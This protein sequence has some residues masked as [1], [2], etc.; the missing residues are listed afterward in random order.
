VEWV[1]EDPSHR[2]YEIR[3][4]TAA[5]RPPLRPRAYTPLI[6]VGDLL[7]Y[8]SGRAMPVTLFSSAHLVD[9]TGDGKA[10]LVG[11]WNYAYRPGWPWSGIICYPRVGAADRFEF[12]GLTRVRYVD[13]AGSKA[14]NHFSHIYMAAAFADF[15]GDGRTDVVY[16]RSGVKRA[17]FYLNTGHRDAAGMPV[18]APSGSVAAPTWQPCHALDLNG[19]GAI[20]LVLGSSY[21]RNRNPNGWPFEPAKAVAL[22]AGR[23]PA[24]FDVDA[25][26]QLDAVCLRG[27]KA[28]HPHGYRVAWRKGLGGDPPRFGP[29]RLLEGIDSEMCSLVEAVDDGSRRGLLVQHNV[30]QEVA[31]YEHVGIE[32][33]KPSFKLLGRAE[34]K[35]AVLSMSDQAWPCV[36]DWDSDGEWD[37]LVGGG[38]GWPRI[39]INTGTNGRPA[40]AEAKLIYADGKPDLLTCVEWSVYP[41]F[42][43]VAI[44]M[45]ALPTCQLGKVSRR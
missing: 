35:T 44:E 17:D 12:G 22:D 14:Y 41:F 2:V 20:D 13:E 25:D 42:S 1:I 36:C 39:A 26:G 6:G 15:N 33:D 4:A 21:I 27:G 37:L 40:F 30:Y 9:L 23:R 29:E 19:D 45:K 3:F 31:F 11:C 24:F 8:N 10:D 7:R 32:G 28:F 18:F 16:T 38:Y 5:R 34:S 43:H